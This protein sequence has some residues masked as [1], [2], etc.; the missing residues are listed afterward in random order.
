[1]SEVLY[2]NAV[3][4]VA[5]IDDALDEDNRSRCAGYGIFN[6]DTGVREA[7]GL[8]F[9]EARWRADQFASMIT[10]LDDLV[11]PLEAAAE[12]ADEDV[13]LN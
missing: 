9:G 5:I 11:D 3:Y 7:T 12:G 13:T 8:V 1:M 6:K 4:Q 2:E 10:Q